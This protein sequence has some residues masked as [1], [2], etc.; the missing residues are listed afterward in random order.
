[1]CKGLLDFSIFLIH[2]S[3]LSSFFSI[4]TSKLS[5]LENSSVITPIKN[6]KKVKPINSTTTEKIYSSPVEPE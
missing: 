1:M 2:K 3:R 4:R 5:E 6:E